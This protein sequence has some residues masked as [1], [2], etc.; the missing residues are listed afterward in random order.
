MVFRAT[1]LL[2]IGTLEPQFSSLVLIKLKPSAHTTNHINLL[3][4][5]ESFPQP[6]VW[7]AASAAQSSAVAKSLQPLGERG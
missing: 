2:R 5:P 3:R 7:L 1:I 4:S 6:A